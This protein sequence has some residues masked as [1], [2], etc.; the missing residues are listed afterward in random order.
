M[1]AFHEATIIHSHQHGLSEVPTVVRPEVVSSSVFRH[2]LNRQADWKDRGPLW[3]RAESCH[4]KGADFGLE[5][6]AGC[7]RMFI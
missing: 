5:S 6:S 3:R 2:S 4:G 7:F 1:L